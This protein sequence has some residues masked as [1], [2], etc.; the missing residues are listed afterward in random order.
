MYCGADGWCYCFNVIDVFTR[1][2][3]A[4]VF[5]TTAKLEGAIQ[6]I[7]DA[8][9]EAAPDCTCLRIRTDNGVQYTSRR[10][11]DTLKRLGIQHEL[12]AYKTPEQNGHVESFHKTLK[13]EYLW[14]HEFASFQEAQAVIDEAFEDYNK[15]RIHS[16]LGYVTPVE[17]V[18]M[19]RGTNK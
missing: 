5:D 6:S 9:A 16:A 12:I 15:H 17:F 7:V 2:W 10:F 3:V 1:K 13:K 8:V 11:R 18:G 14:R 19:R 4:Y